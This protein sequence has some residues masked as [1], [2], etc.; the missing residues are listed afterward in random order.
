MFR[1]FRP[2][3]MTKHTLRVGA[4]RTMPFAANGVVAVVFQLHDKEAPMRTVGLG[5]LVTLLPFLLTSALLAADEPA[6]SS[7]SADEAAIRANADKYVEA[8]NRRDSRTMAG[9]WSPDAVYMEPD[10]GERFVG[11]DA[12][13]KYF[14]DMLAGSEDA[15]LAVTVDSVDFVSPNVAIE[16]GT[17]VVTYGNYP[18]EETTYSAVHVKRDGKWYLDRVS[19]EEVAAPPPSH[20]DELKQLEWLVGSWVDGDGRASIQTKVEWTKNRNFLR[21]SFAVVLGDQIDM[22]GMQIIGWDP[23]EKQ[24]RSWVFDSEGGFAEGTWTKKGNRWFIQ[25]NGTL[26]DGRKATSLNILTYVDA[27]SFEW[28]SVNREVDG[29]L[30]PNIDEVTV[31]RAPAD[32]A[33]GAAQ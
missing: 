26:A 13:A 6:P 19:E 24:I 23:A 11:R 15:K 3:S 21:R 17:A 1:R 32:D 22:S 7:G 2:E 5:L 28:E 12:I 9:M 4:T 25:N 14:D 27:N 30:L 8:Y 18:P 33:A 20:Y 31:V 16:K 10:S 29:E